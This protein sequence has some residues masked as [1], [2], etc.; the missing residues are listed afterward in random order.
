M[1]Q[2]SQTCVEELSEEEIQCATSGGSRG[3]AIGTGLGAAAGF[4]A[5]EL[6][7][8][9]CKRGKAKAAIKAVAMSAGAVVGVFAGYKAEKGIKAI[10][11]I[12]KKRKK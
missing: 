3:E 11:K 7:T 2:H 4:A 1:D 6:G 9:N 12:A 8:A 5:G 10:A